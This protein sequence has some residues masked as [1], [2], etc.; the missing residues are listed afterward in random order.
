LHA[1]E[2]RID[3][4]GRARRTRLLPEHVPRLERRADLEV[5]S[6]GIEVADLRKAELEMRSEPFRLYC[7][8]ARRKI[9]EHFPEIVP[10]E[11]RQHPA[12][13]DRAA[14][15]HELLL[16][17]LRPERGDERAQKKLLRKAHARVRRHLER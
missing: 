6:G 1:L 17:R 8:P 13:V 10:D 15:A 3:V 16:V 7:V 14:P 4:A 12:V 2:R 9:A 5:K 11:M